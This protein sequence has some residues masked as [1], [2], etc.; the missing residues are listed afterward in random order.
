MST[1]HSKTPRGKKYGWGEKTE[2]KTRMLLF[3][4]ILRFNT[5]Y[6]SFFSWTL[7]WE[8]KKRK[9]KIQISLHNLR[10]EEL[11]IL[12]TW[13]DNLKT[14]VTLWRPACIFCWLFSSCLII[15]LSGY[16]DKHWRRGTVQV[17]ASQGQ[18][19]Q[20]HFHLSIFPNNSFVSV[21]LMLHRSNIPIASWE[22]NNN[23]KNNNNNKKKTRNFVSW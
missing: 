23:N 2:N 14:H 11:Q 9:R 17:L 20:P 12:K 1:N 16:P 19:R 10:Q 3:S 22:R 5:S 8:E 4:S 6:Q 13:T 18:R 15:L 7:N 21:R